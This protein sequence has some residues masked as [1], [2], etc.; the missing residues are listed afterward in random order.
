[1]RT[2]RK[3]YNKLDITDEE[4]RERRRQIVARSR[5][6][7]ELAPEL[8]KPH[9]KR[10]LTGHITAEVYAELVE[11]YRKHGGPCDALCKELGWLPARAA[12]VFTRGYKRSGH[13]PIVEILAE[14]QVA[15]HANRRR[16]EEG[17]PPA[18]PLPTE[19]E[20]QADSNRAVVIADHENRRLQELVRRE[21]ERRKAR[22]DA[23]QARSEEALLLGMNRR[24]AIALNGVTAQLMKGAVAL[25]GLIQQELEKAASGQIELSLDHKLKL[26]RSAASV[27]RFNSEA[28]MLAIKS[29]RLVLGQPIEAAA[30]TPDDGSLEQ[31]VA[32]IERSVK[33]VQRA[34]ARGLL[35]KGNDDAAA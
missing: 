9:K 11:V 1:M 2:R 35:G 27:A 23:I 7:R 20:L 4:R 29:E 17:L 30:D 24:N 19:D 34:R 5:L 33:A 22:E 16:L 6:K 10:D 15:I 8:I 3:A 13:R 18:P 28:S 14:D 25:A 31:A 21:E 26:V 32:W 12:R